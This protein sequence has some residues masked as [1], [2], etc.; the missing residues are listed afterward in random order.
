MPSAAML[1]A[2]NAAANSNDH[3]VEGQAKHTGDVQRVLVDALAGGGHGPNIDAVIDA[4]AN[5]G[6]GGQAA[7]AALASHGGAAVSGWDMG[8]SAGFTAD[9]AALTMEHVMALHASAVPPAA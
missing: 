8:N 7:I 2:I 5:Q 1:A 3:S 4:V 9:H 6:H